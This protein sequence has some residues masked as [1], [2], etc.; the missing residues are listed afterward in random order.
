MN[1]K[2]IIFEKNGPI[3]I[4]KL[5]RPEKKHALNRPM[6]EDLYAFFTERLMDRDTTV[7]IIES[8]GNI[9]C[10]GA[11]I[12]EP[13]IDVTKDSHPGSIYNAQRLFSEIIIL[14][15]RV[16]QPIIAAVQGP[17]IGA[18]FSLT[19]AC[20]VR[21]ASEKALFVA[22]YINIGLGGA[23][24]G[25]SYLLPRLVGASRAYRYLLTGENIPAETAEKIGLVS[26]LV[27]AEKLSETALN[28]ANIMC[29]KNPLGLRMTKEA[30][31]QNLNAGSLEEAILLEDR[32]QT[33]L[34]LSNIHRQK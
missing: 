16:P 21:I 29:Q 12:K 6:L 24:M 34:M 14:M 30:I 27:P 15:R 32:N 23:D 2:T 8:T 1:Y 9:F 28:L 7:I 18:G 33:L 10:A 5:N 20:D 17:A 3:G 19:M 4:L 31:N 25:S 26:E 11:D 22:A 13:A